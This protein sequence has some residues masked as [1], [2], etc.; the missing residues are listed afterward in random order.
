[1]RLPAAILDVDGTLVDT[2]YQH[3]LAWY[4]AF[5]ALGETLPLHA[6]H[7]HIGMGGDQLVAALAGDDFERE[8]GD[9]VR[10]AEGDRYA[11]LIGEVEPLPGARDLL[12]ALH[13]RGQPVV[14]AS[15][16]KAGEVEHYLDL[17]D[18]RDLAD[19]WTTSAD[20]EATKPAPDLVTVAV[21]KAGGGPAVMVG[22][23]TWD[24]EAAGR[25]GVPAIGLL[26]GGFSEQELC[27]AGAV[28]V[29]TDLPALLGVLDATPLA[30][31]FGQHAD[32]QQREVPPRR[33]C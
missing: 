12:E 15:S 4:R 17:L 30:Q 27:D 31:G 18:A 16:A 23:S 3:A 10:A 29:H 19:D 7:R 9:E 24:C 5:R 6:I 21:R 11:E 28:G 8:H 1:M 26:T 33:D 13:A 20:V 14:L 32:G 25:A 2:N 22:D